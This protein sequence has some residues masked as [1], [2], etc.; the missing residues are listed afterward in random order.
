MLIDQAAAM[1]AGDF[2]K[3]AWPSEPPVEGPAR[4][5]ANADA[6]QTGL[7]QGLAWRLGVER[8]SRGFPSTNPAN[9]DSFR[10]APAFFPVHA[11][12]QCAKARSRR[13]VRRSVGWEECGYTT[14]LQRF[15]EV[16]QEGKRG[17]AWAAGTDPIRPAGSSFSPFRASPRLRPK[18]RRTG[19]RAGH[20]PWR[21]GHP[22]T[23]VS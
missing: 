18:L 1:R 14:S 12:P 19:R 8:V 2:P 23:G 21:R 6:I 17:H 7:E 15:G 13:A 5:I 4:F 22:S 3:K 11:Y 10:A 20:L 9:D 16:V